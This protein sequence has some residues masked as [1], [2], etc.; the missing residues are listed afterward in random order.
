MALEENEA[1]GK[2]KPSPYT[3]PQHK[4]PLCFSPTS[5]LSQW[6]RLFIW[7]D[8]QTNMAVP[9][10]GTETDMPVVEATG[11]TRDTAASI[12][13][14]V[15]LLLPVFTPEHR[16]PT[17]IGEDINTAI[18]FASFMLH[19]KCLLQEL[20]F[21]RFLMASQGCYSCLVLRPKP[22]V[23]RFSCRGVESRQ[24]SE[25]GLTYGR[26]KSNLLGLDQGIALLLKTP[27]PPQTDTVATVNIVRDTSS[28]RKPAVNHKPHS[29]IMSAQ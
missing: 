2:K 1:E 13:N 24:P 3:L 5:S 29:Q 7:K 8:E 4:E 17:A 10:K 23:K 16:S 27:S 22:E 26:S 28:P 12:P 21:L 11:K 19:H 6:C 18:S 20:F 9:G 25:K 14:F 15:F